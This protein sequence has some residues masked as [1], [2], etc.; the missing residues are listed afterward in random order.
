[1]FCLG[2]QASP[3]TPHIKKQSLNRVKALGNTLIEHFPENLKKSDEMSLKAIYQSYLANPN[4][5]ALEDDASLSYITTLTTI[6]TA[7]SI[8]KHNA[9]HQKVLSKKEEKVLSCVEGSDA[10]CLD[11]ETTLEF[12]SGGGAYLPGLDD[13]FI[14][15]RVI[16]F[17]MVS[18]LWIQVNTVLMPSSFAQ[19]HIV[20]FDS[21][22]KIQQ[23]RLYWDQGSLLKLVDVIGSRAK[24]W[25]IRDGKDQARLIASSVAAIT[26][27]SG[28]PPLR[29]SDTNRDAAIPGK[30][31]AQSNNVTGDPHASLALFAPR[32]EDEE[33]SQQAFVAHRGSAKPPPRDYQDLFVGGDADTSPKAKGR[34]SSPQKENMEMRPPKAQSAKP[35]PRNYHDLFVGNESDASPVSNDK[36]ASP[37]KGVLSPGHMAPK[38]GA[39]KNFKPSRIFEMDEGLPGT[40]K[41]PDKSYKSHPKRYDHFEFGNGDDG[42]SN[43]PARPNTKHQ[44]QW[45]FEDFV[46]PQKPGNK[47]RDQDKRHFGWEDDEASMDSPNKN[48]A[49]PKARPDATSSFEFR[50]DGTPAGERRPAGH[51]RG[52]GTARTT[53]LYQNNLFEESDHAPSPEKKGNPLATVTNLKDRRKDFDSQFNMTDASPSQ[54]AE[55]SKPA[56]E[57]RASVVSQMGAQLD[58]SDQL[59]HS[60]TATRPHH[61]NPL[62]SDKENFPVKAGKNDVGIKSAGDGMGGKKGTG[63]SWG[64]GDDSDED[65]IGGQNGGKFQAARRQQAPKEN[66]IWDF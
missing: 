22:R 55:A 3:S 40:P 38:G 8:V 39:G 33:S 61:T 54:P 44:S 56:P 50:D 59:P 35:P 41:S 46:T 16:T 28:A 20:H 36:T 63:R 13:N 25:P 47:V 27:N 10:V 31:R 32:G 49:I 15:D 4:A 37:Q 24:N 11:I 45:D 51:P 60:A 26:Q 23:I 48:P 19:V 5:S 66:S 6:N 58:A 7:A 52:Q 21:S 1:M 65:G 64:F 34:A 62:S 14:A 2:K 43:L 9:A 12:I 30:P 57:A 53:S 29:S 17:P 18:D 42:P